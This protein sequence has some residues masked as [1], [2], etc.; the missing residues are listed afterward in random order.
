MQNVVQG[1]ESARG[2]EWKLMMQG[3]VVTHDAGESG[4]AWGGVE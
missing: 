2:R 4:A 1:R 3:R